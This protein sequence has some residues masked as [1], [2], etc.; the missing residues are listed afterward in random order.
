MKEIKTFDDDLKDVYAQVLQD[1]LKRINKSFGNFFRRVRE[2][3]EKPG[4]SRYKGKNRYNS[5]TYPQRGFKLE[6]IFDFQRQRKGQI[7]ESKGDS[8]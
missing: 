8:E 6:K 1:V 3:K 7:I 2:R 5:F 4:Y